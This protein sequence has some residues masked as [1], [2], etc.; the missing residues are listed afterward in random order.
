[1]TDGHGHHQ[2][3]GEIAQEVFKAAGD[4]KVFPEQLE[5][6]IAALAA[7]GGLLRG[8]PF[9][10][11]TNGA[12]STTPPASGRRRASTT[13]LPASGS[14]RA[15]DRRDD[16]RWDLGP[17][18]GPQLRA[19]CAR[20][21]GRAEVAKRRGQ[22]HA[23]RTG[24]SNYHLW[25]VAPEAGPFR[26]A[27]AE[28]ASQN[29]IPGEKFLV[30]VHATQATTETRLNSVWLASR[31][32]DSWKAENTTAAIDSTAPF[33]D[34]I[35]RVQAAEDAEPTQPYFTRPLSSSPTTTS[36]IRSGVCAPLRPIRWRRGRSLPLTVCRFVWAR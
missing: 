24:A 2:V 17:G 12:C 3:S 9:A 23:E 11:V 34:N 16:S 26:G 27:S 28:E 21:M 25:A 30:R 18:A 35:F 6:R 32:G 36:L 22:P 19:D 31:S 5:G 10:P 14:G 20:G 15:L 13:T 8:S 33:A 7:A 4:P 1:V 29:V